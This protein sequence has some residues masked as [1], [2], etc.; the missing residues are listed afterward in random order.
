MSDLS[1]G[2]GSG[3]GSERTNELTEQLMAAEAQLEFLENAVRSQEHLADQLAVA[4]AAQ[5]A[6]PSLPP[7][8]LKRLRTLLSRIRR[9][10]VLPTVAVPELENLATPLFTGWS[11]TE[12]TDARYPEWVALY[13]T[14]DEQ[15]REQMRARLDTLR[16]TP[17]VSVICPVYNAPEHFLREAIESVRNQIYP[18]WELCL[19]DDCSTEPHVARILAEYAALDDR[20][21]VISREVNG[22]I[23]A[24]SNSAISLTTGRWICLMDHDDV[25]ASHALAMVAFALEQTPD[26]GLIYSDE[27]HIFDNGARGTPYFKPDFDPLLI[28]GQNYFSHLCVL[29]ADLVKKVGGFREGVEGSQ[30]WDLVLRILEEVEADQ[31]VHIPH[32]LYHWRSHPLSTAS[33]LA[34]KPY[35]V[36]ASRRV[37]Q[38][39]LDR[40]GVR[41]TATSIRGSSFNRINWELPVDPPKVSVILLPRSGHRLRRCIDSMR[42][43][44]TYQNF[45]IVVLDDG[46]FRPPM[47]QYLYDHREW[48]TIVRDD[49]DISDSAQRNVATTAASG[50]VLCFLHD[51]I[52]VLTDSWLEEIVGALSYP[53]IGAIGTK[54]LYPDLSIQHAGIVVGIGGTVGN[55]HRANFDSLAP[56][57]FGRLMLAQCPSAVSWACMAVRREAFD[58]VGGFSEQ[59]FTGM[60]GDIDFCLRLSKVGWRTGWTPHAELIHYEDPADARGADGENAVRFDR[61]IR[62]LH[63]QWAEWIENDPAYNPNLSL[64]HESFPLA[65]P[66]RESLL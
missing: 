10:W 19:S 16:D 2:I 22:H 32:V 47:R 39:H 55:P 23:S 28:L 60:F 4:R 9:R 14:V 15:L 24:S 43:R 44:S 49:R 61:E 38:E 46:E 21:H 33:S 25:L 13:D 20:I 36:E 56:G 27:D 41:A 45:E 18:K 59:Q 66:P 40:M 6:T 17:L 11:G 53:G 54:L 29:R 42:T 62:L 35:V 30:D 3:D 50:D 57:Y 12:L 63:A 48:L 8:P 26:A 37:V 31:V 5:P 64:A 65:W 1:A 58:A 34:A 51:D 7:L 52:E